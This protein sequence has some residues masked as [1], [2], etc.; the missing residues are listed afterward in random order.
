MKTLH[1]IRD[2]SLSAWLEMHSHLLEQ[3]DA[4][5]VS[6]SA[7]GTLPDSSPVLQT[8]Y[9]RKSDIENSKATVPNYLVLKS[10]AE[11]VELVLSFQQQVTW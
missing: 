4:F 10:D 2:N 3:E 5:L 11:W 8:I 6:E 9:A 1:W 7:L